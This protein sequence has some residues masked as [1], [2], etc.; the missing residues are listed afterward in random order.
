MISNEMREMAMVLFKT[1]DF[2]NLIEYGYLNLFHHSNIA[3]IPVGFPFL[4]AL[5]KG[6][7]STLIDH[8]NGEP[9][10][11]RSSVFVRLIFSS[12]IFPA[13]SVQY[14]DGHKKNAAMTRINQTAIRSRLLT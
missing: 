14:G 11:L 4:A 12:L 10:T 8:S 3:K 13:L 2:N 9:G 5:F 6:R 7:T 1:G